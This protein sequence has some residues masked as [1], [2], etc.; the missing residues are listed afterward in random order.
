MGIK[1]L[2]NIIH[3]LEDS[4]YQISKI[5]NQIQHYTNKN[6]EFKKINLFFLLL[7]TDM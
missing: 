7:I 1:I 6:W 5:K 4:K 2:N 3:Y